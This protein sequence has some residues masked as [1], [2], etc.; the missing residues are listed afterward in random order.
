MPRAFSMVAAHGKI[1][2]LAFL[3]LLLWGGILA[4][5]NFDPTTKPVDVDIGV[6]HESP[7]AAISFSS[8][9]IGGKQLMDIGNDSAET[10]LV[11]V[12]ESWARTEVRGAPITSVTSDEPSFGY[13]KWSI[14]A[15]ATVS[16]QTEESWSGVTVHNPSEQPLRIRVT[17]VD[18]QTNEVSYDVFL[19]T[20]RPVKIW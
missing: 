16:F 2:G 18:L 13:A 17:R 10:M 4:A 11:S 5:V 12:P 3:I 15:G 6:E 9:M 7:L 1:A 19:A 8:S 14:P 20:N